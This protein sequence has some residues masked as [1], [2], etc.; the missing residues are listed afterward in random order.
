MRNYREQDEATTATYGPTQVSGVH[1]A[2]TSPAPYLED[3]DYD[4][5]VGSVPIDSLSAHFQPITSLR[6]G[7]TL[8]FEALP[9]CS[10]PGLGDHEELFARATFEKKVGQLGRVIRSRALAECPGSAVFISVHPHELKDSWVIRPDDPISSHDGEIYLQVNQPAYSATCTH[11]LHEVASRAGLSLVADDFGAGGSTL[12]RLIDLRPRFVK[13]DVELVRGVAHDVRK[14]RVIGGLV[15]MCR[16][17][18]AHVIAKGVDTEDDL[19]ALGECG[20]AYGQGRLLGA[21]SEHP[22]VSKWPGLR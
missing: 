13:L 20:V 15:Q 3:T 12:A 16:D 7:R 14:R 22:T 5:L 9:R 21:P 11:V 19:R 4:R 6:T 18:D 8:A 10:A 17:L 1:E 2:P